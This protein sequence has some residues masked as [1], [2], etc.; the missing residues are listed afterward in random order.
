MSLNLSLLITHH[1]Q[2]PLRIRIIIALH[3]GSCVAKGGGKCLVNSCY[4]VNG[5]HDKSTF[6]NEEEGTLN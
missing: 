1:G 4:S 3:Q 2:S 6:Y 5:S